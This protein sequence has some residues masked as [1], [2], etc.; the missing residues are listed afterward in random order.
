MGAQECRKEF[1]L[2]APVLY[3]YYLSLELNQIEIHIGSLVGWKI[4]NSVFPKTLVI[5]IT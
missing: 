2:C 1:S 4:E 5:G 3:T